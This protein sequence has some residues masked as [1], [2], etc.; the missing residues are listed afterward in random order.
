[1]K[2]FVTWL[3]WSVYYFFHFA[4]NSLDKYLTYGMRTRWPWRTF[5]PS[6]WHND[7]GNMWHVYF[8]DERHFVERRTLSLDC[9]VNESGDIVGFDVWDEALKAKGE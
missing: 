2:K 9:Y 3:F 7:D 5:R 4:P 6:V 8:T 1:M